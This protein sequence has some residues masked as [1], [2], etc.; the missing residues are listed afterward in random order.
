VENL[1]VALLPKTRAPILVRY[2]AALGI[3]GL[4]AALR[5]SL[6]A[7]LHNYPLLLFIPAIFF[8]ALLF[9]KGS[10]FFATIVSTLIAAYFFLDPPMSFQIGPAQV[11]PLLIFT[12]I[13]FMISAVTEALRETVQKLAD[14]EQQKSLLLEELAH[15]TKNDLTMITSV[16]TLQARGQADPAA[17]AALE[18]AIMRVGVIARAQERLR[19]GHDGG[20]V[21]LSDYLQ[22]LAATLGDL[23]R[24]VRP[25][26]VRV[27]AEPMEM[28]S[29]D[30]VSVGL[31]VNELV[32][33]A[34][35]YA[36]PDS[37]GGAVDVTV[38]RTPDGVCILVADDGVGCPAAPESGLGS[39]LIR[40]LAAQLRGTVHRDENPGGGCR[41]QVT[42]PL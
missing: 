39:R 33:N 4:T 9:D 1:F 22:G 37:R 25:I 8:I 5:F 13:G 31:I 40:M 36:F 32:T 3:I 24:D 16:L 23:L 38:R 29:S 34:F 15:R 42:L 20:T 21:E 28:N 12:L 35:K 18:S 2:L 7:Q 27:E 6:D 26:A 10:G 19:G 30:A 17:R 14:A 11:L 41:V